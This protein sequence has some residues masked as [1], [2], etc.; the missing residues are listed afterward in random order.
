MTKSFHWQI[1]FNMEI[2]IPFPI[3][4]KSVLELQVCSYRL[5]I[6]QDRLKV[7]LTM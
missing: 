2:S 3:Q 6:R 4:A 5:N 7:T 1:C